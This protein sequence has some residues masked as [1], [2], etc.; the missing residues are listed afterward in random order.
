MAV[1]SFDETTVID[2]PEAGA[3][4]AKA[5][6]MCEKYK[7]YIPETTKGVTDNPEI[8]EKIRAAWM[9]ND[10]VLLSLSK[11]LAVHGED[12][13]NRIFA[14]FVPFHELSKD[15]FLREDAIIKEK[16]GECRTY[17][18]F[19]E[20]NWDMIGFFTVGI[21][22]LKITKDCNLPDTISKKLNVSD[23]ENASVF[24]LG[25]LSYS[26]R[27]VGFESRLIDEAL[28]VIRTAHNTVGCNLVRLDCADCSVKF[29][30]ERGFAIMG[31]SEK[32]GLNQMIMLLQT[33]AEDDYTATN[34]FDVTL[35]IDT[36]E[37]EANLAKAFEDYDK[38]GPYIPGPT[39][40]TTNDPEILEKI[41]KNWK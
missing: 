18:A 41:R 3:N 17:I 5:V 8:I 36:P 15:N 16:K 13:I 19:N 2:T 30:E 27:Y 25:Q 21:R 23:N 33:V 7:P 31:R 14:N 39:Q 4:L 38:Y 10:L 1:S 20:N 34:P 28:A 40:G 35:V 32:T 9:K 11:I 24:V 37:A 26:E 29:Y 22:C 12:L 6:E